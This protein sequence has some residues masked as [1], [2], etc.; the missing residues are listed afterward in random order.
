M[1]LVPVKNLFVS[2][3]INGAKRTP[4]PIQNNEVIRKYFYFTLCFLVYTFMFLNKEK[5]PLFLQ[6]ITFTKKACK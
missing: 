4:N 2:A 6:T 3:S 5:Y 1:V